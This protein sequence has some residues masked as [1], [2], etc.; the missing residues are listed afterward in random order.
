MLKNTLIAVASMLVLVG[1]ADRAHADLVISKGQ[2]SNVNCSGGICIATAANAVLNVK[3][4]KALLQK[5]D[6]KV[7]SGSAAQDI[8]VSVPFKWTN[9]FRLTLDAYRSVTFTEAVTVEGSGAVTLTINDGGIDG[10]EA[11]PPQGA[12]HVLGFDQQLYRERQELRA[13]R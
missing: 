13:V 7:V 6:L 10:V 9:P 8:T 4:L 2:T 1:A 11:F 12:S 3:D 5:A